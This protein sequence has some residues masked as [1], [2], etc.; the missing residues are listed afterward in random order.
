[1]DWILKAAS[2]SKNKS[3]QRRLKEHKRQE[4][5]GVAKMTNGAKFKQ[6][7]YMAASWLGS[8]CNL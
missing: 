6:A 1:M 3:I 8:L 4:L 7:V 5:R 2:A